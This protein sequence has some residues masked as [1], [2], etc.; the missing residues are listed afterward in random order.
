MDLAASMLILFAAASLQGLAGFGYS[1]MSLPLLA[2]FMPVRVVV[3]MLSLTSIFLNLIVF[4]NA[5]KWADLRRILPLVLAGIVS[6]PGGV[7]ILHHADEALL[8]VII[9][10]LVALSATLYLTGFRIRIRRETLAMIPTGLLSG[11]MNGVTTFS[12]PPVILF[13]ANQNVEK[14]VFRANLALYFLLLN[15]AAVPAFAA[16]GFL[17]AE[18]VMET[19][20]RFPAV[21]VGAMLGIRFAG[22]IDEVRFRRVSLIMLVLLGLVSAA[23]GVG[24]L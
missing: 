16:G 14:Q 1:L 20:L 23:S 5:R 4:L 7:W 8:R 3:P 18:T 19:A 24:I 15:I 22:R 2:L 12:G 6:I 17:T 9:G 11:L 13:L 21:M 10:V